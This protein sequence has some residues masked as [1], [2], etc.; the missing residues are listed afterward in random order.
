MNVAKLRETLGLSVNQLA[1]ALNVNTR[2]IARWEEGSATPTGL[3]DSV[4]QAISMAINE[5]AD[6]RRIGQRLS[7]GVG[8]VIYYGLMNMN[9]TP[10]KG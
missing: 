6:A 7:L 1:S 8:G 5:G 10:E 3:A 4:L 9:M 2:T